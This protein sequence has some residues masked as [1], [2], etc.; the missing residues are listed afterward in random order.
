MRE[1]FCLLLQMRKEADKDLDFSYS[2]HGRAGLINIWAIRIERFL[3]IKKNSNSYSSALY[4]SWF[5]GIDWSDEI[6][7]FSLILKILKNSIY[8]YPE[9]WL[10][11]GNYCCFSGC[12]FT[13][14]MIY[15]PWHLCGHQF[16]SHLGMDCN[17]FKSILAQKIIRKEKNK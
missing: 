11:P 10:I 4:L 5:L 2:Y 3:L 9:L 7:H 8:Y 13:F 12:L 16:S 14:F 15:K 6:P 17:E 1:N